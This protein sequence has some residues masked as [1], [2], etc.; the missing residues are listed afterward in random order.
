[1]IIPCT[2]HSILIGSGFVFL[3]CPLDFTV[4]FLLPVLNLLSWSN[5]VDFGPDSDIES[6]YSA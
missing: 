4:Y 3:G 1:M 5:I 6:L 2:L